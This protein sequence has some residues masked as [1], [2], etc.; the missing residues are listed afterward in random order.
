MSSKNQQNDLLVLKKSI[1]LLILIELCK[2]KANY[3]QIR[4][5]MGAADN[6]LISKVNNVVNKGAKE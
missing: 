6:N 5:L 4:S 3:A 2:R 1:D